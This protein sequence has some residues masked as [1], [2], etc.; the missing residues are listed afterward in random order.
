MTFIQ[1]DLHPICYN[2]HLTTFISLFIILIH[3]S[4]PHFNSTSFLSSVIS[5]YNMYLTL[6]SQTRVNSS[7][8]TYQDGFHL[9]DK[10]A[11][12]PSCSSILLVISN[13]SPTHQV[14]RLIIHYSQVITMD[15][16]V[17][18]WPGWNPSSSGDQDGIHLHQVTRMDSILIMWLGW[19]PSSSGD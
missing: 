3:S 14:Q 4:A 19:I 7:L 12:I 5:T 2:Y 13:R 15:S 16:M 17:V 8:L 1:N 9:A 10:S 6:G 18:R 11:W